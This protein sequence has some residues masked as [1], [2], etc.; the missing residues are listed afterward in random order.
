MKNKGY[1]NLVTTMNTTKGFLGSLKICE[2]LSMTTRFVH[3]HYTILNVDED[4]R[5][6]NK[7]RCIIKHQI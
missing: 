6:H 3:S 7:W 1:T 4:N 2:R 5:W